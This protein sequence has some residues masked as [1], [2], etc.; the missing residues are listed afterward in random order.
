MTD[1]T[2]QLIRRLLAEGMTVSA[3]TDAVMSAANKEDLADQGF[4]LY[5]AGAI[6]TVAL[7]TPPLAEMPI[8]EVLH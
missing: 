8:P 4:R 6:D 1:N 3:V 7:L 2:V 5:L